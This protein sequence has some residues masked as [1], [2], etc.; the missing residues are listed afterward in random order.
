MQGLNKGR[1]PDNVPDTD[2]VSRHFGR[3]PP[4]RHCTQLMN[5]L[6]T[7]F[8]NFPFLATYFDSTIQKRYLNLAIAFML[9]TF[10]ISWSNNVYPIPT[11]IT[12]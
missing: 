12:C 6:T 2:S 3:G 4:M 1:W 9:L 10:T 7:W 11:R 8:P 5:S